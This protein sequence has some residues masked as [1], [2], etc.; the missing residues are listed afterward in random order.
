MGGGGGGSAQPKE[1]PS[2]IV[3]R[4]RDIEQL[5]Q[6]DEEENRRIKR[7]MQSRTGTRAFSRRAPRD[8]K[9]G[10]TTST[11]ASNAADAY[12]RQRRDA[13]HAVQR[14][15]FGRVQDDAAALPKSM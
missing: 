14:A 1:D 13:Y 12:N 3:Q 2:A 7:A 5:A 11:P 6:L 10:S 9:V 4:R 8:T 15:F